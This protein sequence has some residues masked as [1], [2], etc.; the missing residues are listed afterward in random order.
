MDTYE[1]EFIETRIAVFE[2]WLQRCPD[3]TL[4]EA[5]GQSFIA[6]CRMLTDAETPIVDCV[7]F[8][9]CALSEAFG[10][11]GYHLAEIGDASPLLHEFAKAAIESVLALK[12]M[13]AATEEWTQEQEEESIQRLHNFYENLE[14]DTDHFGSLILCETVAL[15]LHRRFSASD[16]SEEEEERL[17]GKLALCSILFAARCGISGACRVMFELFA[18]GEDSLTRDE[19]V[20]LH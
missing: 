8:L 9:G 15:I 14:V 20:R 11:G 5:M 4:A 18:I 10:E 12:A 7:N 17:S 1:S 6:Q 19:T 16:V 2:Q 13:C 3:K